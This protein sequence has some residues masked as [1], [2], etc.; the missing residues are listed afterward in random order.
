MQ[1]LQRLPDKIEHFLE[2][3]DVRRNIAFDD[4]GKR[5]DSESYRQNHAQCHHNPC[6]N[7]ERSLVPRP[8]VP[9]SKS[10]GIEWLS[11]L[12]FVDAHL[13]HVTVDERLSLSSNQ[14]AIGVGPPSITAVNDGIGHSLS[15]SAESFCATNRRHSLL[16]AE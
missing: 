10:A 1:L 14:H 7:V 16:F 12:N 9:A 8:I 13:G 11:A 6:D 15:D 3:V 4:D 2:I 5:R